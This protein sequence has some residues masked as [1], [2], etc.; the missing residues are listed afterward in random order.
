MV[1]IALDAMG[2]DQFPQ[3]EVEGAIRAVK[4]LGL[5][6]ILVGREEV[7]R[8]ELA[9]HEGADSLPIEVGHAS[10]QVTMEDSAAK[11]MRA[12]P[13]RVWCATRRS[14]RS[15]EPSRCGGR[16]AARVD[17]RDDPVHDLG[18]RKIFAE[19]ATYARAHGFGKRSVTQRRPHQQ[20]RC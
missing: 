1:T 15:S 18:R 19:N 13:L 10:E 17:V 6:V 20:R 7:L 12:V 3:P 9:Q 16:V 8:R 4:T 11:A 5:K 2:G 14:F